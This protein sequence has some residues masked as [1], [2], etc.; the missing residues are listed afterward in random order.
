MGGH[1]LDGIRNVALVGHG[2]AG[3]T[4]LADQLL[5]RSGAVR[6]TSGNNGAY[7]DGDDEE[8]ARH[9][10]IFSHLAHFEHHG[11]RIN[12]IDTPGYPDFVG[13]MVGALRAVETAV[14]VVNASA[15]IEPSTRR[16]FHIAGDEQ[17]AR[18]IVVNKCDQDHTHPEEIL[19]RL[20]EAF[21][22][23]CVALNV[24]CGSGPGLSSVIGVV[25][26]AAKATG[27]CPIDPQH[28]HQELVEAIVETDETLMAKY[29]DGEEPSAEQIAAGVTA[30]M[31]AGTLIPVMFVSVAK[32]VGLDEL[33]DMLS[34]LAPSPSVV[35][36]H[37]QDVD[38]R[39]VEL[40]P[41][42]DGPFIGQVF[43][44][45][46]DPFVG[47]LCYIRVYSGRLHKDETVQTVRGGK[48]FK[49]HQILDSQGN[50]QTVADEAAPG[51]IVAVA[52]IDDLH[53]GD[54]V[55]N[56]GSSVSLPPIPFPTPMIGLA[57]EPKSRADQQKI[58]TA[59][60]KIEEE[61]PT[62]RVV[63]DEQTHEM[64]MQG[65][66]ELHLQ[67]IRDR[68]AK[69]DHVEV[70][71][72]TPKVPYRETVTGSSEANYRHKK[73][74]GGAGQF[75]E[76]HLRVHAVPQDIDPD[77]YFTKDR[78]PGLRSTHYDR[79][80]NFAFLD[81]VSGGSVPNQYIPAVEKGVREQMTHGVLA[82]YSIRDVA[83]ELFFGKDHPV[84]SNETA[85][86]TAARHCFK[87]A[88]LEAS[89]ALLEP[90]V[91][92]EITIPEAKLGDVTSDLTGRR[93]HVEGM[94]SLPGGMTVLRA[95]VPLAEMTTYART[96]SGMTGGQGSF[97]M[98]PSH[99]DL[100]PAHE[101]QKIVAAATPSANG[102]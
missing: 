41:R 75:A 18:M 68:L 98:E 23:G 60:H 17:L 21:G 50:D 35:I 83:V 10:S 67:I 81:C 69:R 78:F 47:K 38:G 12:L 74:T 43:K 6:P 92:A 40:I 45:K 14:I 46:I 15:G 86:K 94:E 44:T 88:F 13:Q 5:M 77:T 80:L 33:M 101:Q 96:L 57:V 2:A 11:R 76:V 34:D 95:N 66:S 99:H 102:D 3:K 85:F 62:V 72:H 25:D 53:V 7:L 39:D 64:V 55:T 26:P 89:P 71:T 79:E 100:V 36:H 91:R 97:I 56:N 19:A 42:E 61:D 65:M 54:T 48:S 16:A 30:A 51:D 84:D 59:L 31:K 93:G 20:R 24:P 37:A 90:V 52:K 49:V 32:G 58:S 29:F 63:R 9:M 27:D 22:A 1:S 70:L 8:R 87:E 73:Q 4:S 28:A 82:G